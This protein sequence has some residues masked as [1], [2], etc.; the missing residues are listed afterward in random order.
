MGKKGSIKS[1]KVKCLGKIDINEYMRKQ[2]IILLK[3]DEG[4]H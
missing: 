3:E 1:V 2:I 4:L